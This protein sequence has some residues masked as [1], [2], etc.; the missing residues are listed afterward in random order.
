MLPG[1]WADE[2]AAT[3]AATLASTA[4][5]HSFCVA[6]VISFSFPLRE[7][8]S[9]LCCAQESA[10]AAAASSLLLCVCEV[11][12]RVCVAGCVCEPTTAASRLG[13]CYLCL[14]FC[15]CAGPTS[16]Y[17][18]CLCA[19]VCVCLLYTSLHGPRDLRF[20]DSFALCAASAFASASFSASA[21]ALLWALR[22]DFSDTE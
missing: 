2:Q 1:N 3:A 15:C 14:S 17:S 18:V 21:A 20:C 7:I 4:T 13:C 12:V 8:C 6:F 19:C 16:I 5:A 22:I 9:A 10:E 11:S